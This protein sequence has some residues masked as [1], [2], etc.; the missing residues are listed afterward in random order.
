M[1]TGVAAA[2]VLAIASAA[3]WNFLPT[4]EPPLEPL[5]P[6]P[7]TSYPGMEAGPTF[8]PD[9]DR[10]AFWWNGEQPDNSDIY[11]KLIGPGPPLRLTTDPAQDHSPAW[12]PDG[13]L[14]RLSPGTS[15]G[16]K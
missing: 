5:L 12:S 6:V 11:V 2:V 10:V 4:T 7:L 8:S 16:P 3:L 1:W 9:G 15:L 13:P 14:H